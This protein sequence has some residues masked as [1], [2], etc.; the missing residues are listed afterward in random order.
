MKRAFFQAFVLFLLLGITWFLV[1]LRFCSDEATPVEPPPPVS[2]T[3]PPVLDDGLPDV[4]EEALDDGRPPRGGP[5]QVVSSPEA[6]RSAAGQAI[7]AAADAL[8]ESPSQA[9]AA[10]VLRDLRSALRAAPRSEAVAAIMAFLETERDERTRLPFVVGRGGRLE[11]APALRVFLLDELGSIDAAAA[12][13]LAEGGFENTRSADEYAIHL[14]NFAWGSELP[15]AERLSRIRDRAVEMTQ[16]PS[17]REAPTDGFAEAYDALV[18]TNAT[19]MTQRLARDTDRSRPGNIRRPS[20]LALDR[21]VIAAPEETLPRILEDM[22]GMSEQPFTRAGYF[23][24]VDARD[25]VQLEIV[26]SYLLSDAVGGGERTY[27]FD[28]FPNHN[29]HHSRNLLSENQYPSHDEIVARLR[30]AFAQTSVWM[31]DARFTDFVDDIARANQRLA[32]ILGET[33]EP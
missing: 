31:G 4:L 24:R 12:A 30:G 23:A 29:F 25:P 17:W 10:G 22:G 15:A 9:H 7:L 26:E 20:N 14:R 32:E 18:Y 5:E 11:A 27:F 33:A 28:L 16:R 8:A 19:E 3:L 1:A 2:E 13:E 6:L 21:L